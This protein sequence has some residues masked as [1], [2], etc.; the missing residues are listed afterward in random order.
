MRHNRLRLTLTVF[1]GTFCV[2]AVVNSGHYGWSD[3]KYSMEA[4]RNF[5][6]TGNANVTAG[7]ASGFV[8][9]DGLTF[10]RMEA[11][12]K[13]LG[14]PGMLAGLALN[15]VSPMPAHLSP[16]FNS[17]AEVLAVFSMSAWTALLAAVLSLCLLEMRCPHWF[18]VFAALAIVGGSTALDMS[19]Y[20]N[21]SNG[22][23][24]ALSLAV[25]ASIR[26]W[27]SSLAGRRPT[28]WIQILFA[29]GLILAVNMRPTSFLLVPGLL[30]GWVC[31][32]RKQWNCYLPVLFGG[33]LGVLLKLGYNHHRSGNWLT[34]GYSGDYETGFFN[35][36]ILEGLFA[37]LFVPRW[38]FLINCPVTLPAFVC[39]GHALFAAK[40]DRRR[41]RLP[42]FLWLAMLVLPQWAVYSIYA[43][44]ELYAMRYYSEMVVILGLLGSVYVSRQIR[45]GGISWRYLFPLLGVTG[46][47]LHFA[48]T[49]MPLPRFEGAYATTI[50][51]QGISNYLRF[52]PV[53][54]EACEF[55]K[56]FAAFPHPDWLVAA[57]FP[58]SWKWIVGLVYLAGAMLLIWAA[59]PKPPASRI[60]LWGAVMI[61]ICPTA[62][63]L[64]L[65]ARK[66]FLSTTF[67]PA[68]PVP[69]RPSPVQANFYLLG[70]KIFGDYTVRFPGTADEKGK[71]R[72]F[73]VWLSASPIG[74]PSDPSQVAIHVGGPNIFNGYLYGIP[75]ERMPAG[76]T[77]RFPNAASMNPDL[78][79]IVRSSQEYNFTFYAASDKQQFLKRPLGKALLHF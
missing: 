26:A 37:S 55:Y 8:G 61:L 54:L 48:A 47:V 68:S 11:G 21:S 15:R 40:A 72:S 66:P 59:A 6:E 64:C 78:R 76:S 29:A 77:M 3:D 43:V 73:D 41:S 16:M 42:L 75:W 46:I 36:P 5:I 71:F 18:A 60:V 20:L 44:P 19:R 39:L 28:L 4:M 9:R 52:I 32:V 30:F 34:M 38:S 67:D 13:L 12:I 10:V 56:Q 33:L 45:R 65:S 50:A 27:R 2:L 35:R 22:S 14:L 62:F 49:L 25:Y 74:P 70:S 63:V 79:D 53:P 1:L 58:G 31:I 69:G 23:M 57:L 7:Y 24:L 17:W 51:P